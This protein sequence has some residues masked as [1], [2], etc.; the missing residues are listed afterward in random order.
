LVAQIVLDVALLHWFANNDRRVAALWRLPM[1]GPRKMG[2][3]GQRFW[4]LV[5]TWQCAR[6]RMASQIG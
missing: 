2:S 3:F 6:L 5:A 1:S 4:T